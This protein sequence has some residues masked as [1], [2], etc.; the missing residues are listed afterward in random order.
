MDSKAVLEKL[1]SFASKAILVEGY[2]LDR[3]KR[4]LSFIGN[5]E[6]SYKI[7]HIGGTAGKGSTTRFIESMLAEHGLKTGAYYSPHVVDPMERIQ[8]EGSDISEEEFVGVF[9]T[10]LSRLTDFQKTNPDF[11]LTYFEYLLVMAFQYFREEKIDVLAL[12]VGLGGKL[13]PTNVVSSDIA[14]LTNVGLDHMRVLGDTVSEI[15][16]DK[17]MIIKPGTVCVTGVS[18]PDVI[19]IVEKRCEDVGASMLLA[20]RDFE[21]KVITRSIKGYGFDYFFDELE[22]RGLITGMLGNHQVSNASLAITAVSSFLRL[23][24]RKAIPMSVRSGLKSALPGRIEVIQ[25]DPAI[26]LDAAHNRSKMR[27]LVNTVSEISPGTQ[28]NLLLAFKRGQNF[29]LLLE[30][31]ARIRDNVKSIKLTRY[32]VTQDLVLESEET[33]EYLEYLQ[34]LFPSLEIKY[35]ADI[36]R[37]FVESRNDLEDDETLLVTGSFYLLNALEQSGNYNHKDNSDNQ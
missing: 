5:P 29:K 1:E 30:P 37:A 31:L 35:D 10:I 26:I 17:M 15:A 34:G 2:N 13:D 14:V 3:I 25:K 27:A 22:L 20:G 19:Q 12:E 32:K 18:Q 8:I 7:I 33:G 21:W 6:K 16:R 9:K 4:F 36:G 11:F 24:D 23:I 28:I